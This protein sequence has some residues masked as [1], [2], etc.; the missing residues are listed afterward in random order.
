MHV[1]PRLCSP[2]AKSRTTCESRCSMLVG[3]QSKVTW[4]THRREW[5]P[6]RR[7]V[8]G[9]EGGRGQVGVDRSWRKT[10]GGLN[11]Y[12]YYNK[13]E[14]RTSK[15]EIGNWGELMYYV[16]WGVV[17]NIQGTGFYCKCEHR[18]WYNVLTLLSKTHVRPGGCSPPS[19]RRA[20]QGGGGTD[21]YT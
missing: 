14:K 1:N 8:R 9:R 13:T 19:R 16:L 4:R 6:W 10:G 20:P 11:R 17:I 3:G 12:L 5:R 21:W 7:T 2:C 15:G 18:Q